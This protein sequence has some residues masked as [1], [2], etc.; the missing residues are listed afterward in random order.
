MKAGAPKEVLLKKYCI[1]DRMY[2]REIDNEPEVIV[3]VKSY[4]F[5]KM[6]SKT[7]ANINFLY[8]CS[9]VFF[10]LLSTA[11]GQ[12]RYDRYCLLYRN[13]LFGQYR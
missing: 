1:T 12:L 4:E 8:F 2:N 5:E 3:K 9:F 13:S 7:S 6:Y 10:S 11:T